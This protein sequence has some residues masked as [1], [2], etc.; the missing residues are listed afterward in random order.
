MDV[1]KEKLDEIILKYQRSKA[2]LLAIFQDVQKEYRYLPKEAVKHICRRLGVPE[3]HGFE[4]ATFYKSLSLKP[5]GKHTVHVCLGTA[6]HLKGGADVLLS[7]I[8]E[9]KVK[10]GETTADGAFTLESVNCL[11]ACALAPLVRVDERDFGKTKAAHIK[12][13]LSGFTEQRDR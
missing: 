9:L 1:D 2:H 7:F 4:V 12:S 13:I 3:V 11:G 10:T 6:C 5:R 8:R